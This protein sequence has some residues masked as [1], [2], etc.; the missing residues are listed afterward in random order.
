[1]LPFGWMCLLCGLIF[2]LFRSMSRSFWLRWVSLSTDESAPSVL[3][4]LALDC[5]ARWPAGAVERKERISPSVFFLRL[6]N[7]LVDSGIQF[8][9]LDV[10][11]HRELNVILCQLTALLVA[12]M[13]ARNS[14]ACQIRGKSTNDTGCAARHAENLWATPKMF[15]FREMYRLIHADHTF[16]LL[17]LT[18]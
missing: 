1:M 4:Y 9:A 6:A 5:Y 13:S 12:Q 7:A 15:T 8:S 2:N 17:N 16:H 14:A 11:V 10:V 18:R 3:G